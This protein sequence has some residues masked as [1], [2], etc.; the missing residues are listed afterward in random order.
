MGGGGG[1][2]YWYANLAKLASLFL[3][4]A[5]IESKHMN[6]NPSKNAVVMHN[7]D[8]AGTAK[9]RTQIARNY[10]SWGGSCR[11]PLGVP[12]EGHSGLE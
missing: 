8:R 1:T 7:T 6:K 4:R 11:G 2:W 12:L 10:A 9:R 5:V 3:G